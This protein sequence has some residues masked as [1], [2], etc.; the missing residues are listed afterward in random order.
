MEELAEILKRAG[1][2]RSEAC[3]VGESHHAVLRSI[4][5]HQESCGDEMNRFE[6]FV[7]EAT[8]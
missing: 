1:F 5:R 3:E 7:L 2:S 6:T 8:K 4:E